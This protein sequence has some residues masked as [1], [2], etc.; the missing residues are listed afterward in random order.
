MPVSWKPLVYVS[1]S[2]WARS[3]RVSAS[4]RC[5]SSK[6]I[7]STSVILTPSRQKLYGFIVAVS[8]CVEYYLHTHSDRKVTY[9]R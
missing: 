5:V 8:I 9:G 3:H 6:P 2:H 7:V 4:D 1:S